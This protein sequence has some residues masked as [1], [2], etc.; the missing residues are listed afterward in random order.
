MTSLQ[1]LKSGTWYILD[2]IFW[3]LGYRLGSPIIAQLNL[4][5]HVVLQLRMPTSPGDI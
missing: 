2:F 5:R 4:H 1:E 3:H